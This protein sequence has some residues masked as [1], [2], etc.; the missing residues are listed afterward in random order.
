KAAGGNDSS[1]CGELSTPCATIGQGVARANA[2][3]KRVV[4]VA[5]G[6]YGGFTM[7]G[8]VTVRGGYNSTFSGRS[9]ATTVTGNGTGV[10]ANGTTSGA[11]LL[12]LTI[13]SG[14]PVGAGASAYGVRAV[15]GSVLTIRDSEITAA[16][17]NPGASAGTAANG[18]F[19]C[20]GGNGV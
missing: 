9:G 18:S 7:T 6:S 13:H 14:T 15:N 12:D 16:N 11:T 17:G 2:A 20:H 8:G 5:S 19:I 1:T 4:Q 3:G 10:L